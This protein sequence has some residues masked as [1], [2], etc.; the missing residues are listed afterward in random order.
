VET[1]AGEVIEDAIVSQIAFLWQTRAL[2]HERLYVADE[3]DIALAYLRDI[4]LPVM[5]ALYARWERALGKR[6]ASFLRLG[7][8]IGGDR[9]GNPHVTADSL[10]L[11]L[12]KS[13]QALLSEYLAQLNAL[14]AELSLSTEL[15]TV[16]A[17]VAAL[18]ARSGDAHAARADE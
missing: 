18:A 15:T 8:W 7:S 11:A 4:F 16:S 12:G 10:R 1:G 3:V 6:P 9:D 14:G 5:P 17:E 2:R 13:S